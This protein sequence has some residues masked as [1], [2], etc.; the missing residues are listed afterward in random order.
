[1]KQRPYIRGMRTLSEAVHC[2]VQKV[3]LPDLLHGLY[4]SLS[5]DTLFI[6]FEYEGGIAVERV[7]VAERGFNTD[8]LNGEE[9]VHWIFSNPSTTTLEFE[10]LEEA[11]QAIRYG[12]AV[13]YPGNVSRR[14][15]W[16]APSYL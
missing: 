16:S 10:S 14:N 8:T 11:R 7:I 6:L 5:G 3:Y 1:M 2:F 13:E 12:D 4:L 9:V 15:S